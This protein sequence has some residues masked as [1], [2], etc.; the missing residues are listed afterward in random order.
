[1]LLDAPEKK[2]TGQGLAGF[3]RPD[4]LMMMFAR[5]LILLCRLLNLRMMKDG[6]VSS[7][8]R[9]GGN[10]SMTLRP[11]IVGAAQFVFCA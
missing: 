3:Q 4:R 5:V 1:M 6:Q 7:G 2:L 11:R 8:K 9:W 10:K